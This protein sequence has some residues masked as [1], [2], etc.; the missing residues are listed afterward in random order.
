MARSCRRQA[1][2][3]ED[4]VEETAK[5]KK[6]TGRNPKDRTSEKTESEGS[7]PSPKTNAKAAAAAAT[8][9]LYDLLGVQRDASQKEIASAYRRRALL[10]HPDKVR[11]R[12][13]GANGDGDVKND[14]ENISVEEATK[15]FQQ[16]QAAYAVLN[17]PKK[18]ERY[19]RT[20][21]SYRTANASHHQS[22]VVAL[23]ETG[24]ESLE[25]KSYEEAYA[26]YRE[27]F[28]EVTEEAI[29]EF[30]LRYIG[31]EEEKEDIQD[32]VNRFDGDLSKFFEFVPLS[33]PS[34]SKR[35]KEVLS[36]LLKE[37]KI[38]ATQEY[39]KSFREFDSIA[40]KYKKRFEKEKAAARKGN[41]GKKEEDMSALALSILGNMRKREAASNRFL[42]ELQQKYSKKKRNT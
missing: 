13:K 16:L 33:D 41:G 8:H 38:K 24:E 29:N 27:K 39:K 6:A 28:P 12:Q 15:H 14:T 37:K 35:Y 4:G 19:D 32:F 31:S 42:E 22:P 36:S 20:G 18:R 10:C 25:G 30:K 34:E 17:D 26:F 23:R 9:S 40:E 5:G 1:H 11:Q 7:E 2:V 3:Q 21:K